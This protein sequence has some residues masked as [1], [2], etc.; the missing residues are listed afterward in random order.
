MNIEHRLYINAPVE[1]V[2][3]LVYDEEQLKLW[4]EDVV[5]TRYHADHDRTDPVG[6]TFTQFIQE[7]SR[8]AEYCGEIIAYDPLRHL[9]LTIGNR[10]FT[11]RVEYRFVAEAGQT[12]LDYQARMIAGTWLMR[13]TGSLFEGFTRRI[14]YNQMWRLK[15]VAES[16][17]VAPQQAETRLA[18]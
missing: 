16:S 9:S 18:A 8:R 17:Y 7:G 15:A 1:E 11:M 13:L 3:N 6:T 10:R 4:A 5:E 2:F 14:L 12:R